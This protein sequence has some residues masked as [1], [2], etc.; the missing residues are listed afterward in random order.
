MALNLSKAG[1]RPNIKMERVLEKGYC[2]L[3]EQTLVTRS[4]MYMGGP[5]PLTTSSV[6]VIY[7][8]QK[9]D[10]PVQEYVL[11]KSEEAKT[12]TLLIMVS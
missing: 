11:V 10:E 8:L 1:K 2:N 9:G 3:Y 4:T 6:R 5:F 12:Y 7:Y